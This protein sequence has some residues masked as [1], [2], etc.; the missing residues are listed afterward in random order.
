MAQWRP[1]AAEG[2]AAAPGGSWEWCSGARRRLGVVQRRSAAGGGG[3]AVPGSG[4]GWCSDARQ[5]LGWYSG[6]RRRWYSQEKR[7][8][9][10]LM[11]GVQRK[12]QSMKLSESEKK[13]V[14][15]GRR[16]AT[17]QGPTKMQV[18]GKL[19]SDKPARVDALE[20]ALGR[21]W[22]PFKGTECKDLGMN[23]FLFVFREEAGKRKALDGGPWMFNK[24]LLVIDHTRPT[25]SRTHAR[26]P[27][28]TRHALCWCGACTNRS[29]THAPMSSISGRAFVASV[30]LPLSGQQVDRLG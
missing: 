12:L 29:R 14:R 26:L 16:S 18:I 10:I 8:R 4:W 5:R 17:T 6:A 23:R 19:M 25:P 7:F 21:A 27:T 9:G 22:C 15:I 28:L 30:S 20:T 11:E 13:G 1:A 2:G 24:K 3:A